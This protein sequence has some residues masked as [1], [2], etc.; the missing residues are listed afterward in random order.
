MV[1]SPGM[2]SVATY[3]SIEFAFAIHGHEESTSDT[4]YAHHASFHRRNFQQT[5]RG[6]TGIRGTK[7]CALE[8]VVTVLR[9]PTGSHPLCGSPYSSTAVG[10][11]RT[12]ASC[13]TCCPMPHAGTS[14]LLAKYLFLFCPQASS[15]VDKV[16]ISQS[17]LRA[18]ETFVIMQLMSLLPDLIVSVGYQSHGATGLSPQQMLFKFGGELGSPQP[19]LRVGGPRHCGSSRCGGNPDT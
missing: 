19:L 9:S 3:R 2:H 15:C 12:P 5:Y 16:K 10:G 14:L 4:K 11:H 17:V 13:S 1:P 18:N 7:G 8:C 6:D